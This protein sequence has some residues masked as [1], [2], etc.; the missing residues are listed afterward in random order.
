MNKLLFSLLIVAF[1]SYWSCSDK[2]NNEVHKPKC[3]SFIFAKNVIALNTTLDSVRHSLHYPN[4]FD[5]VVMSDTDSL[6]AMRYDPTIDEGMD[7]AFYLFFSQSEKKLVLISFSIIMEDK[8]GID[9][10]INNYLSVFPTLKV[11]DKNNLNKNAVIVQD[12]CYEYRYM[13]KQYSEDMSTIQ[14]DIRLR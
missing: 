5:R 1:L 12:S 13:K 7:Y 10:H 9:Y 11:I 6:Y 4:S 3:P 14:I 2:Q 8:K